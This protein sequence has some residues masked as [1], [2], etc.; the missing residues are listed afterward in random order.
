MMEYAPQEIAKAQNQNADS[1]K[2]NSLGKGT[3]KRFNIIAKHGRQSKRSEPLC[4]AHHAA[5]CDCRP[6]PPDTPVERVMRIVRRLGNE[7]RFTSLDKVMSSDV[8]HDL[9]PGED[10]DMKLL[11]YLVELLDES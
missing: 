6:F 3:M 5:C 4:E 11:L 7:D 8:S 1:S 9:S 2:L 10:F